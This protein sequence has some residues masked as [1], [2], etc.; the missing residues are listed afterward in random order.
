LAEACIGH[1]SK[2]IGH[3]IRK[4]HFRHNYDAAVISVW[5]EGEQLKGKVGDMVLQTGDTL[6]LVCKPTFIKEHHSANDGDFVWVNPIQD[7]VI[8]F[9]K[10]K[11]AIAL[12]VAITLYVLT[13]IEVVDL[14]TASLVSAMTLLVTKC[15]TYE[16]A[17]ASVDMSVLIVIAGSDL[18]VLILALNDPALI[19]SFQPPSVLQP[20]SKRLV[21]PLNGLITS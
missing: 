1:K 20:H 18:F 10:T 15:V 13:A 12:L 17:Q 14:M 11:T 3:S 8:H 21:L 6:L 16:E 19:S 2:L 4:S 5:R 9:D 7:S